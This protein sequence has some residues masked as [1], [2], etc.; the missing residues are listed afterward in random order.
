MDAPHSTLPWIMLLVPPVAAPR[1]AAE[2]EVVPV[3][4]QDAEVPAVRPFL[5]FPAQL[6]AELRRLRAVNLLQVPV[7][8]RL[9]RLLVAPRQVVARVAVVAVPVVVAPR[10]V[11]VVAVL[12]VVAGEV[13]VVSLL[14]QRFQAW[15]SSTSC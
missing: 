1:L 14:L 2:E 7:L 5:R 13:R 4:V 15:R 3:V 11:V 12:L 9:D 10:Q 8:L 6:Q